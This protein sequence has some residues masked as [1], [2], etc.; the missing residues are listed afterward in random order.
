MLVWYVTLKK[1]ELKC[2]R[3]LYPPNIKS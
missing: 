2:L 3:G 1:G